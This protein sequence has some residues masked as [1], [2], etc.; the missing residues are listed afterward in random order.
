[1]SIEEVTST[2][3]FTV[4]VKSTRLG[5]STWITCSDQTGVV[6]FGATEEESVSECG[7]M[8]RGLVRQLKRNGTLALIKFMNSR[9]IVFKFDLS[10]SGPSA[11]VTPGSDP[12]QLALA[13]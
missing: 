13:A 1:M 3:F 12:E 5:D 6:G 2:V 7:E 11:P 4:K 9:G 8:H 10:S